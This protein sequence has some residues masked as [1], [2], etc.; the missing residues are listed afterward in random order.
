MSLLMGPEEFEKLTVDVLTEHIADFSL[1]ALKGL[2]AHGQS[3]VGAP[4]ATS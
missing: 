4:E 2:K 1:R 3:T